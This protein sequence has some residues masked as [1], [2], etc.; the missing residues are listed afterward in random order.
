MTVDDVQRLALSLPESVEKPHFHMTSFRIRDKIFATVPPDKEY[1]HLFVGELERET[2]IM[3]HPKA[4]EKLWWGKKVAGL[5]V[6]LSAAQPN[7]VQQLL[8]SA[9]QLKAPAKLLD[10]LRQMNGWCTSND[11]FQQNIVQS[12]LHANKT[13]TKEIIQEEFNNAF[14]NL[15]RSAH[16]CKLCGGPDDFR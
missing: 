6:K 10:K 3:L 14:I 11:A 2:M 16:V 4:Y 12:G 13:S 1:L 8:Q 15:L 9:W 7:D 5:R